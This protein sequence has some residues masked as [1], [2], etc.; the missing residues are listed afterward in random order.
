MLATA[1]WANLRAALLCHR[2]RPG[3]RRCRPPRFGIPLQPLQVGAHVGGVLVAQVAVFLQRLVDDLFQLR[4][5]ITIE[6]N[7][8]GRIRIEDCLEDRLPNF[9]HETATLPSPS[10]TAPP[11]TRTDRVRASNSF[12]R[13]CSGD[14]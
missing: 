6:T 2:H 8:R 3:T 7:R 4:R 14:M 13:T 1:V 12:A 9:R 11:R 10:R 5:N